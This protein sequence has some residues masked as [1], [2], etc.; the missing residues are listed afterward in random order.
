MSAGLWSFFR[1]KSQSV[2]IYKRI[3]IGN[4]LII[5]VGAIGGTLLTRH[6]T[7]KAADLSLILLF[8]TLGI[9]VSVGVNFLMLRS[10]LRPLYELFERVDQLQREQ[11]PAAAIQLNDSDPSITQLARTLDDLILQLNKR[12]SQLKALSQRAISVQEEERKRIARSLHDDTGQALSTLIIQLEHLEDQLPASQQ[13]LKEKLSRSR[14]LARTTLHELRQTMYGLRPAMLDDLGLAPA[15]RWYARSHLEEAGIRVHF[16]ADEALDPLP[17]EIATALFRASQ[18]AIN[19]ILKHSGAQCVEIS[20]T[21]KNGRLRLQVKDD[22]QGF[23]MQQT[24]SQALSR[25]QLGLL[26][27]KEQADLV[28]GC[29]SIDSHPGEGTRLELELPLPP[30]Q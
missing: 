26:G 11:F 20:L 28:N 23:D 19:N 7:D 18:E 15:I 1:R 16:V 3:A 24:T 25:Q 4:S 6:L 10:A 29:L 14:Q 5:I 12:N 30:P 8:A 9:G 2:S 17:A 22:G 13:E 27:L 21:K